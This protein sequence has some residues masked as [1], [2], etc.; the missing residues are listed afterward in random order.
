MNIKTRLQTKL[1]KGLKKKRQF[2]Q[3]RKGFQNNVLQQIEIC[4][5][6][7][8]KALNLIFSEA[9][10]VFEIH[11]DQKSYAKC[12]WI[13]FRLQTFYFQSRIQKC[14]S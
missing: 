1:R 7:L 2:S 6:I 10:C 8:L 14:W 3:I 5:H 9:I 13:L 12:S 11:F 4:F